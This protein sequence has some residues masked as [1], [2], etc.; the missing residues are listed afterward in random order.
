MT[1]EQLTSLLA[2]YPSD[3]EVRMVASY[4]SAPTPIMAVQFEERP[5]TPQSPQES[6]SNRDAVVVLM[7]SAQHLG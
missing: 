7:P 3:S 5:S 2:R 1:N 6:T 4:G